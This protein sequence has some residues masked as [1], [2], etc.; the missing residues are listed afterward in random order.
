MLIRIRKFLDQEER[1]LDEA[2]TT[3]RAVIRL[4]PL[5]GCNGV[6]ADVLESLELVERLATV[7]DGEVEL[8]SFRLRALFAEVLDAERK[9]DVIERGIELVRHRA[10]QDP[11]DRRRLL[12]DPNPGDPPVGAVIEFEV[13]PIWLP[14]KEHVAVEME[15]PEIASGAVVL[16][17]RSL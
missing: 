8:A 7:C 17:P 13:D 9:R 11:E 6:V 12:D 10:D 15:G 16:R 5:E 2:V 3:S 4:E 1:V 14:A